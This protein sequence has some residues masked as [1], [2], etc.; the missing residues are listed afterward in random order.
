MKKQEN[1]ES[2]MIANAA[3]EKISET[4]EEVSMMDGWY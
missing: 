4:E 2:A 3:S 1:K